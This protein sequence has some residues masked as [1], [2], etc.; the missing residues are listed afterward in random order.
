MSSAVR[1]LEIRGNLATEYADVLTPQVLDALQALA[2]LDDD[3]KRV[4]AA[5]IA[6][7]AARARSGEPI[8]FLDPNATIARTSITVRDARAGNF[9]GS[10]IPADLTRQWIQ[11]TGPAAKPNTPVDHS[12]RNA[13]YALLSGADGWM[14]DGEDALGQVSAMSLDNQRNLKLAF[15]R[16]ARFLRVAEQVAAEMN[17]WA[18]GF[19]GRAI[20]DDW[21]KQ[22]D[23]TTRIFRPRGLHLDDRHVR[24]ADGRGF[25]ASIVDAAMYVVNNHD[26]LG[27][28]G[29][30][31]VLYLPKIQTAEEAAL[32]NDVLDALEAHL[33]LAAGAIKV[34]VLVEQLEAS[35]QLMEI[36]AA[37]GRHFVGFNTGRW[38]Y[39]NSVADAAAWNPRFVNPNIDAITMTYGYMRHYEDRVRRAVNTPDRSGRFALWQGGMEPNIPVGSE[40]GV[41]SGMKRAVA[42]AE[43]EQ[44]EGASGK[45]VAHWKMVHIVRPVWERVGEANQRGR[46]FPALTHTPDDAANLTLLEPAPRTVRGARDLLS[47]ALQYGNAFGQGLQAAAL[48]PADFFGNEDVLYLMEDMATG[49]IRLSILWEWLHKN[50]ALTDGDDQAGVKS[51]DRF[52]RELFQRLVAEE[53]GKLQHASNRDVHD[54]S[55]KTTL[56]IAREIVETYV[57]EPVKLPWYIDLLNITLGNHDLSE[58]KRRIRLLA[59]A[60]QRDGTRVTEN[61]DW[62]TP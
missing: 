5:R 13:A 34:Y 23:F 27:Q 39:I 8:A 21:R 55:K 43:R 56:P 37:L 61:L 20:V 22:L 38:D 29:A 40:A 16:D 24:R 14:F 53:Y 26:A 62:E 25:S 9:E 50:A 12:I 11:G 31:L 19:F 10:D 59:D 1:D 35:F 49:E 52:T 48:K 54:N 18:Q 30:S 6:R 44:R 47:V 2:H 15:H 28:A 4:M 33:G 58:A 45:W 57:L 7:R 42:G 46:K 51:G 17:A 41:T 32:W 36:R 3:R 60:F